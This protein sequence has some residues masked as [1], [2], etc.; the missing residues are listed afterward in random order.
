MGTVTPMRANEIGPDDL[1]EYL[2][3]TEMRQK[4]IPASAFAAEVARE[5]FAT[6][7]PIAI[8]LPWAKSHHQFAFRPGEVTLWAGINGH[9]KSMLTSQVVLSLCSQN[10]RCCVASFEMKPWRSMHRMLRQASNGDSPSQEWLDAFAQWTD[11]KLWF[12]D[13]QGTVQTQWIYALVRYCADRLKITHIVIDSLMKCV[14]AEDDMNGQKAFVDELTALARDLN[15]HIHLVHHVRK[16]GD[17]TKRISKFDVKGSGAITDQVDNVLLVWRNKAKEQ[18]DKR[19]EEPDC[20]LTC[21]KQR[22]GEWEGVWSLW[23]HHG[24]MQFLADGRGSPMDLL[25]LQT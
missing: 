11:G 19:A 23:F 17:E 9:G 5:M 10:Q 3:A 2:Q 4:V 25:R 16:Q 1:R 14:K 21:D 24:A 8:V 7:H 12:Y 13:Q 20:L 22:N 18:D 6:E 15:V